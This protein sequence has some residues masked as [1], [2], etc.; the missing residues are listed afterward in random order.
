MTDNA[1]TLVE[2]MDAVW[3]RG[4]VD[5]VDRFL[6]DQYTIHSD[7]GD[8]WDGQ[9][10]TRTAFKERLVAS[11]APFPD[12]HFDLVEVIAEHDRVAI[13]WNMRGTQTGQ[14]G[15]LPPTGRPIDVQGMTVYYFRD[16]RITGHRQVVD[17]LSVVRQL[18]LARAGAD[19]PG[20]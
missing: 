17:R 8:P 2:F 13:A 11:R 16:G 6:A 4:N 3:N 20:R 15:Q 9:T 10:L 5:A 1:R 18:G 7:P 14:L 12:L 19:S